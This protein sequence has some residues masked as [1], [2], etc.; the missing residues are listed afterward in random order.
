[1]GLSTAPRPASPQ[2]L[3]GDGPPVRAGTPFQGYQ[4]WPHH[5]VRGGQLK[6]Y[7]VPLC[8][9][10]VWVSVVSNISQCF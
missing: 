3:V 9:G 1:V 2:R 10:V 4:L 5:A 8:M 7:P 6:S